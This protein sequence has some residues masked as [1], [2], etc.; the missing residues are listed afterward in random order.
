[1]SNTPGKSPP[2]KKQANPQ[3]ARARVTIGAK[4]LVDKARETT[5]SRD[6][7]EQITRRMT[8]KGSTTGSS[9]EISRWETN[10]LLIRL[11]RWGT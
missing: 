11:A 3:E 10:P 9:H 4:S 2:P 6:A 8:E 7:K 5:L 1:M